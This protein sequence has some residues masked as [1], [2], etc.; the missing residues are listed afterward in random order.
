MCFIGGNDIKLLRSGVEYFPALELAIQNAAKEIYLQA[1]IYEAD[2]SG[3]R[4]GNALMQAA[5]DPK[6]LPA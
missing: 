1:Y 2:V 4:I 6:Y 5:Q 3:I